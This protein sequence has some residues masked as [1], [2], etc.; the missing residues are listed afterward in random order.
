MTPDL[1]P[2]ERALVRTIVGMALPLEVMRCQVEWRPYSELSPEV[3]REII[4][5][6]NVAR[7]AVAAVSDGRPIPTPP[8]P[9]SIEH[10]HRTAIAAVP[11]A[12]D[13]MP[14]LFDRRRTERAMTLVVMMTLGFAAAVIS[15]GSVVVLLT[16][17]LIVG[18][19]Y[20]IAGM[21]PMRGR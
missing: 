6:S 21:F 14:P 12:I 8:D 20:L 5:A 10:W 9:P 11:R 1:T 4:N 16:H 18:G 13:T 7:A 3:Q 17:A 15:D 19:G 2:R